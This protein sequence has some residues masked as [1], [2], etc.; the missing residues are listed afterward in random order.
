MK[1][2]KLMSKHVVT[3]RPSDTLAEAAQLMWDHDIGVL[4][5]VDEQGHVIG[6]LTDRDVCMAA[7]TRGAPLR[8]IAVA[9]TMTTHPVTCSP[10]AEVA[11]IE[12][13][14]SRRQIRR[15]PVVDDQG[16][17]IGMVSLNDLARAAQ[18]RGE[19]SPGEVASTLA[20]VSAPRQLIEQAR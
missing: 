2:A 14:M 17:A 7:Y 13:T 8:S 3:C 20:A 9:T 4:P 1:I 18:Q 16:H 19:I 6:V 15:V 10:D 11:A 5:V 12:A